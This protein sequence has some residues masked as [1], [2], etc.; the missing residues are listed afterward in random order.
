MDW[1][2]IGQ[3]N[4]VLAWLTRAGA[5][6]YGRDKRLDPFATSMRD[7]DDVAPN[8]VALREGRD[9]AVNDI[10]QRQ[11]DLR[12]AHL[13]QEDN[14]LSDLGQA[15]IAA[16][17]R[18]SVANGDKYDEFARILLYALEA[19]RLNIAAYGEYVAYWR[20]L[21]TNFNP[22][23]LI[24][25]WDVLFTLN[26]L[27]F[28]YD[29]YAPG[30][31][32]RLARTPV[33]EIEVDL[34]EFAESATDNNEAH[35][36]AEKVQA[37]IQ[38]KVPRGRHRATFA[39]ALETIA[40]NGASLETLLERYGFPE[41]PRKWTPFTQNQK[42]KLREIISAYGLD[43]EAVAVV[44]E[45]MPAVEDEPLLDESVQLEL[46]KDIDFSR[47]L[48]DRPASKKPSNPASAIDEKK[49]S[50]PRKLNYKKRAEKNDLVGNLGE[51][52]AL[53]YERWRLREK[54]E[55]AARVKRVS[56]ED[57][58]LGYDIDSFNLDG[59]RRC[60]EVKGTIGELSTRFYISANE[61]ARAKELGSDYVLLRVGKLS[62][63]PICCE[64]KSPLDDALELKPDSYVAMF[65]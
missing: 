39:M 33:S 40:T 27:D 43:E 20:D 19:R 38:S 46:A 45:L 57:D 12:A 11:V 49:E 1:A 13:V 32:Y 31:A 36:G 54:P 6:R 5:I 42:S 55:L 34:T 30:N 65:K 18:F 47:V 2:G 44:E 62:T 17:E 35:L 59:S 63:V 61:L 7:F 52:F 48:V 26:F 56:D 29:G 24:E 22:L 16:W 41:R 21:R 51:Q 15:V 28:E 3:G 50:T 23:D 10:R 37:S 4:S 64:L 9:L 25:N 58:T 53:E 14:T 60:V 8:L